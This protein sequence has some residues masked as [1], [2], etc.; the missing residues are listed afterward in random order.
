[1]NALP[2][3]LRFAR[4]L[5]DAQPMG[6]AM[7]PASAG[8]EPCPGPADT[9]YLLGRH[10]FIYCGQRASD[11]YTVRQL[12]VLLLSVEESPF[13]LC[14]KRQPE[15]VL[16]AA[17]VAPLVSRRLSI[18]RSAVLRFNVGPAHPAYLALSGL[19]GAEVMS[20]D[21]SAYLRFENDFA[22][23]RDGIATL[24]EAERLFQIVVT[25]MLAQLPRVHARGQRAR[26]M[27]ALIDERPRITLVE[28]AAQF[29]QSPQR[30]SRLFSTGVGM[31]VRDYKEF[32][33]G[34]RLMELLHTDRSLTDIALDAGF[35]DSSQLSHAFHRW[36]GCSPSYLRNPRY[37]RVFRR[38]S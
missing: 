37:V 1:M 34:Q 35:R 19:R 3:P 21:R 9:C 8:A 16:S 24:D 20:L 25:L 31:S 33:R 23:L 14:V 38:G 30:L 15:M 29:A 36:F 4:R 6:S 26:E 28:L 27:T 10:G 13:V 2:S 5:G 7:P 17:A 11:D 22:R 32:A 12:G 18:G